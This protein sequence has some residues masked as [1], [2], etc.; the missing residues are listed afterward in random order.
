MVLATSTKAL[1]DAGLDLST[2][3]WTD[4][5]PGERSLRT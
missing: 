2:R 3:R 1:T 5:T 4:G